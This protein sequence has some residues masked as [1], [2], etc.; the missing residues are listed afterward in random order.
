MGRAADA[1]EVS[2]G[3]REVLDALARSQT[4]PFRA[5]TQAVDLGGEDRR[6]GRSDPAQQAG[7]AYALE[8]P[9]DGR[10]DWYLLG[11]GE[12][13]LVR[14]RAAAPPGRHVQAVQRQA[15]RG[16]AC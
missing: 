3:Q 9:H 5:G 6:G 12:A 8:L 16:E 11:H 10:R 1:L 7:G 4:L 13:D 15:V 14:A 2:D